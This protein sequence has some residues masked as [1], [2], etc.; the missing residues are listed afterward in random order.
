MILRNSAILLAA[1]LSILSAASL[2]ALETTRSDSAAISSRF[3]GLQLALAAKDTT[4][5][6]G[7]YA[8]EAVSLL[9]NQPVRHGRESIVERWKKSLAHP[10]ALT[11]APEGLSLSRSGVDAFQHG[12]FAVRTTDSTAALLATGKV[13]Y[14]WR[15]ESGAWRIALEMDNFDAAQKK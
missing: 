5:I 12:T 9:Q 13:L 8:D 14:V 6:G 1:S 3:S 10:I 15:K 2:H 7:F 11:V 4:A